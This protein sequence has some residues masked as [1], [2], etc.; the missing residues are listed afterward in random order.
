M[1]IAS[2]IVPLLILVGPEASAQGPI[3]YPGSHAGGTIQDRNRICADDNLHASHDGSFE[4][5]AAWEGA[6]VAEPYVGCFGEGYA[7]GPGAIECVSLWITTDYDWGPTTDVYVWEGGVS[8]PPGNV[9]AVVVNNV[10]P[11]IPIWPAIGRYDVEITALV[12]AEFTVGSWGNWPDG[13]KGY[14]WAIDQDG[15]AG[16]PWT[17]VQSDLGYP[18]GW[19]HPQ[20]IWMFEIRS[21]GIGA[22]FAPD[23]VPVEDSSW[24]Q[25]KR[26]C[27][28]RSAAR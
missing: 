8:G 13:P 4:N 7:L 18:E 20:A 26:L 5:G 22:H 23:P 28:G 25:V 1:R 27:G 11:G 9:L 14:W 12:A 19:Q 24:G 17:Y 2:I 15:P 6:G 3:S 10:F 16:H 21:M